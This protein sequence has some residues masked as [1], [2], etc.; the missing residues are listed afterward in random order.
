M[1]VVIILGIIA[2]HVKDQIEHA[3]TFVEIVVCVRERDWKSKLY[4]SCLNMYRRLL[5]S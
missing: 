1:P 5:L 4:Q 2:A 3:K